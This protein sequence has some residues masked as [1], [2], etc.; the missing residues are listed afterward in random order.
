M[1]GGTHVIHGLGHTP[2]DP[3]TPTMLG[4]STGGGLG[5]TSGGG[6]LVFCSPLPRDWFGGRRDDVVDVVSFS[7]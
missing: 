3:R 5:W 1:G 7:H 6:L 4:R 2:V